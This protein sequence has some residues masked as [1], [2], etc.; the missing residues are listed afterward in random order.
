MNGLGR[1]TG[2]L[3]VRHEISDVLEERSLINSKNI[4]GGAYEKNGK[5]EGFL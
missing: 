1:V 5:Q 3:P 4:T 2:R